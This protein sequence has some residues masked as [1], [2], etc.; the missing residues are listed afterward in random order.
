VE[1]AL[2][3]VAAA[4][5]M[6][7]SVALAGGIST[8]RESRR[9]TAL[10][11]AM[12]ELRRPLQTLALSLSEAPGR[13]QTAA[14]SLRMAA[15]ALERLDREIN[16]ASEVSSYR[17]VELKALLEDAVGRWQAQAAKAGKPLRLRGDE[18]FSGVVLADE[19]QVAQALDNLISNAI[20][21]GSGPVVIGI[22]DLDGCARVV[23]LNGS[24]RRA[25][26]LSSPLSLRARL[27]G[28]CRHGHGLRVVERVA[29]AHGG[30][31]RLRHSD[32]QTRAQLELPLQPSEA[33]A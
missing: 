28:R 23:V 15:A 31:F 3:E 32:A 12:H 9:R 16:G 21:H 18:G 5:P 7:L 8:L 4:L 29:R 33:S 22:G 20:E 10:N 30:T 17:P 25:G 11:E 24:S 26:S 13:A 14:S 6:A 27:S 2:T 1:V 19:M